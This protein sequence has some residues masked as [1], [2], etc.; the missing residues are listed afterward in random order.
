MSSENQKYFFFF[1]KSSEMD[2]I[3]DFLEKCPKGVD[4]DF[5][6]EVTLIDESLLSSLEEN[7]ENGDTIGLAV[8]NSKG[9]YVGLVEYDIVN[10]DHIHIYGLYTCLDIFEDVLKQLVKYLKNKYRMDILVSLNER[11]KPDILKRITS[12]MTFIKCE[13][14][15]IYDATDYQ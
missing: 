15:L 2:R 12:S 9:E 13:E 3:G 1:V 6:T 4:E 8:R 14:D 10:D 5:D 11:M 7:F